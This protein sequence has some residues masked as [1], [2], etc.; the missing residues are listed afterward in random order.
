MK[1]VFSAILTLIVVIQLSIYPNKSHAGLGAAA[2]A[3]GAPN[4]G[5]SLFVAGGG[6]IILGAY[7]I[8]SCKSA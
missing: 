5:I 8:S 2:L 7:A 4:I 6:L 1:K 3:G